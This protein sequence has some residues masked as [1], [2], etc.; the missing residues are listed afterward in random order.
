MTYTSRVTIWRDGCLQLA[1]HEVPMNIRIGWWARRYD[2]R[3]M[4]TSW[5]VKEI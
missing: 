2:G 1:I 3:I 4:L 5:A